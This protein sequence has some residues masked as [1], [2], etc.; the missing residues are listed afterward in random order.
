MDFAALE[1][2]VFV[3][4]R[5]GVFVAAALLVFEDFDLPFTAVE[6]PDLR[7]PLAVAVRV[8][9][10]FE[11]LVTGLITKKVESGR[12]PSLFKQSKIRARA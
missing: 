10:L 8:V 11:A 12:L 2:A 6:L 9:D 1:A 7:V 4:L 3:T 5:A